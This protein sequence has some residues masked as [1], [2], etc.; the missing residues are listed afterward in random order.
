[1]SSQV[2]LREKDFA[3]GPWAQSNVEGGASMLIALK[4]GGVLVV[5]ELS[6]MYTNGT[7]FKS[8]AVPITLFKSYER[9]DDSRYLL[10]DDKGGL[11][12]LVLDAPNSGPIAG[13]AC[14]RVGTTSQATALSHISE[15]LLFIGSSHGDSQLVQ[16]SSEPDESNN[17]I[18]EIERWANIGPIVDFSVVD[19]ERHGQ[20]SLVTC[21]GAGK[22][23]SLRIVRNGI[24]INEQARIELPGIKGLWSAHAPGGA[25]Y[26][27][28][29]FISET[30][31]L[32]M[33]EDA[34]LGEVEVD[35]FDADCATVN[36]AATP[37]GS[38]IQ[39][40]SKG[41][42][43]IDGT[44]MALAS[45]W[46]PP[47]GGAIS[48]AAIEKSLVL[49]ATS[50]TQLH[51]LEATNGSW[52]ALASVT[53]E[54]EVACLAICSSHA[55]DSGATAMQT[56]DD[57]VPADTLNIPP[58]AACGLW[59]DL[60]IRLLS[61]PTLREVHNE[62]LGGVVIPRSLAFAP[63]GEQ[64][65]LLCALGDGQL[66]TYQLRDGESMMSD[67]GCTLAERKVV[68]IGTK[69]IN[70]TPFHSHGQLHVF[71]ASDRPTVLHANS[72]GKLLYS[73]V[74]LKTAT[75]MTPF[76][77]DPDAPDTLAIA[78]EDAL[79]LGTVDEVR[80]LHIR[81][82][83]LNEQPRRIAH[84]EHSQSFAVLTTMVEQQSDGE[85]KERNF[86]RL[87]DETTFERIASFE[88]GHQE[89]TCS[90]LTLR[91]PPEQ[92]QQS[93]AASSTPTLLVVGTAFVR[94]DEPEPTAGRIL[95]FD[96]SDRSLELVCEHRVKGATY[97]LEAIGSNGLL[98]G[99]NN[100]L[101]LYEWA[102]SSAGSTPTLRLRAEHVGHIIVLFIAVRG[103]FILV[104]DL[105]KS[106]TVYQC[107]LSSGTIV[108]LARDYNSHWMTSIA[109]LDDDTYLGAENSHNLIVAKKNADATTDDDRGR[110][111]VVGEFHLGEFVNRFRRGSLAMQVA[112]AGTAPLPTLL[113]G[114]VNG[115][116]G[117]IASLPE[118]DFNLLLE[119]Q[120]QLTKVIKGVGG[121]THKDWRAFSNDRKTVDSS[122]VLDG[123]LIESFLS[124]NPQEMA[125]VC[126][127]L[128]G[129]PGT[130]VEELT[131][132]I[133]D[134]ARLH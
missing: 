77:C 22:D 121:F 75:H 24:G 84:L 80:K 58:L 3:D 117:L 59:T 112:E 1:M 56:D 113:Y 28:L 126:E 7:D 93:A 42:R 104:G 38:M 114:T 83:Y 86:I 72:S 54:H 78:S 39:V 128:G 48:M 94:T 73:N 81:S 107:S 64:I 70:L 97:A 82:V 55:T 52:N 87:L 89:A 13:L 19:L 85:E 131:K 26:L 102:P 109:F 29:S 32:G 71:A 98:A 123:D 34:E 127:G 68:T 103:D 53:M 50:G 118:D 25:A 60:S 105:M 67:G 44:S 17:Y 16:L 108:E 49:L 18:Q 115:V 5:G 122:N 46:K 111:E 14:E 130:S 31:V 47:G 45:E 74:N 79:I 6:I 88:L 61:L 120:K 119:V 27:V 101:Q 36:C 69:P 41:V 110:L 92:Q 124:L 23:G 21:S 43:L 8:I 63:F 15:G 2:H 51:L 106:L 10:G 129:L 30:K 91:V 66:M 95:V 134:L 96:V 35:G 76:A 99:V 20:G 65:H 40:T 4:R 11:H 33:D 57:V 37:D 100:K 9:L 132:R 12:V 62:S 125:Q 116:L 90:T 133:E